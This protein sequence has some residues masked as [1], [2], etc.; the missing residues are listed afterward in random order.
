MK[1]RRKTI[2]TLAVAIITAA[3]VFAQKEEGYLNAFEADSAVW[4]T[5]STRDGQISVEMLK[6][7]LYGD[8]IISG[9]NWKFVS[10]DNESLSPAF[11]IRSENGVVYYNHYKDHQYLYGYDIPDE[12][13]FIIYDFNLGIGDS[14][15]IPNRRMKF[16]IT[17]IDS[18]VLQDGKK[19]KRIEQGMIEG[20]GRLDGPFFH[21]LPIPTYSCGHI[22]VCCEVNGQLL[23]LNPDY[24]DCEGNLVS[25]EVITELFPKPKIQSN[26]SQLIIKYDNSNSFD[27]E[28][29]NMQGMK[30]MQHKNNHHEITLSTGGLPPGVYVVLI[31]SGEKV[32]S[33][34]FVK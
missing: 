30:V 11:L 24:A 19:H 29:Y 27:V 3:H 31:Q 8:T 34:K 28:I 22:L 9:I 14:V 26:D 33:E 17:E 6:T 32:F 20:L 5:F 13:G 12:K 15:L 7:I 10:F 16:E 2:L 4:T 23:Y 25:N 1:K 18:V 21:L